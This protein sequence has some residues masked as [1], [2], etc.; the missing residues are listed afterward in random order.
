MGTWCCQIVILQRSRKSNAQ[1]WRRSKAG[2]WRAPGWPIRADLLRA[3]SNAGMI[4][5]KHQ[6]SFIKLSFAPSAL[7]LDNNVDA[8]ATASICVITPDCNFSWRFDFEGQIVVIGFLLSIIN[9]CMMRFA[10]TLSIARWGRR[11]SFAAK[12]HSD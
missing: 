6:W 3:T 7:Q 10:P 11:S 9:L 5:L 1:P 8:R 4:S 12:P 2:Y